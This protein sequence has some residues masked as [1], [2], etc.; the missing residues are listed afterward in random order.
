M[1]GSDRALRQLHEARPAI[2]R[3]E[4]YESPAAL[5]DALRA[6]WHAVDG[7]LRTLLRNDAAASDAVRL[8][9]LSRAELATDAV[10]TELR[11]L[12]RITLGLAGRVHELSQILRRAEA[13]EVRAADADHALAVVDAL[14]A[15]LRGMKAPPAAK[16]A[17]LVAADTGMEERAVAP[18]AHRR[19][20]RPPY[21]LAIAGGVAVTVVLLLLVLLVLLP[22]RGADMARGVEAF[23]EGRAG[24]AEQHFRSALRRDGANVTARLYLARILRG[25]GR[26]QEAADLLRD[27]ARAAPRDAAVRRELGYLSLAVDRPAQAAEQ[28]RM[29]VE[30]EP[31]EPLG[32]VGLVEALHRAGDPSAP[33]WL[34]RAPAS[35]RSMIEAAGRR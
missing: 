7:A 13:G 2:E 4:T 33:E 27:A 15:E 23:R 29:A 19:F 35:A 3:L 21:A 12:D 8:A 32:W 5:L 22:A 20:L 14:E 1:T 24:V 30:L 9:A 17:E 25:Q 10:V 34:R 26:T 18:P 11:R 6:T 16:A 31:E 28:F